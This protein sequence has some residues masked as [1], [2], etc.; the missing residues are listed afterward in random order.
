METR[1]TL[2]STEIDSKLLFPLLSVSSDPVGVSHIVTIEQQQS[3]SISDSVTTIQ[4]GAY[5][6]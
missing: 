1:S 2:L 4:I 5:P 6:S 3:L